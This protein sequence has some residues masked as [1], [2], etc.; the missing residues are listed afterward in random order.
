MAS[1]EQRGNRFRAIFRLG[2]AKHSVSVKAADRKDAEAG[3]VRLEE[4]LRLVERGRLVIPDGADVGLYLVSDGRLEQKVETA[5][6]TRLAELFRAYRENFTAG[7]KE[8]IT[9]RMENIHLNHLLRILGDI[10]VADISAAA[11]QRFV[12]MRSRETHLG[13]VVKTTTVR[14]AVATLRFVMSWGKRQSHCPEKF[15]EVE[16]Y[17]PKERQAEPF[18]TFE[19]ITSIVARGG[20][21]K[22]RITELW[23]GL[24]LRLHEVADVL[25]RGAGLG[26]WNVEQVGMGWGGFS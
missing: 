17:F 15:P 9:R 2:G 6:T 25:E 12:D 20:L 24:F 5:R 18:R 21:N 10:P 13:Q 3:L 16:L 8:K 4:N 23:D 7:A 14:K 26:L 22:E 11:V 19:Q 1:L